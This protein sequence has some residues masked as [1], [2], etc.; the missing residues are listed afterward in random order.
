MIYGITYADNNMTIA[1]DRCIESMARNGV[2]NAAHLGIHDIS[3]TFIIHNEDIFKAGVRGASC[4][5]LFKP[6]IIYSKMLGLNNGDYLI[7]S[8]AGVE[9]INSVNEIISRMDEDIFFFTNTFKQVEWTKGA[10]MDAILPEWRDGRYDDRMQVQASNIF[11]R[12]NDNTRK[13]FKEY[14]LY[15]QM[16]GLIDDS[17]SVTPNFPTFAENRH[18]QSILCALQIKYN[19]KLHWFPSETAHHIK[20]RTPDDHYPVIFRHHR[21]R[22]DQW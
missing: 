5:W 9:F 18:D 8:D 14:L 17:P 4:Y 6:Y 16:P 13:F 3:P 2:H 19:Y 7:Y 1:A 12:V 20:H 11:I 22:N 21:K 15:S 10:V